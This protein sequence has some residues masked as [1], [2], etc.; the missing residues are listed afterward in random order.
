MSFAKFQ[1]R[2][3]KTTVESSDAPEAEIQ[4]T[5]APVVET[6]D[7]PEEEIQETQ[8][9]P[10]KEISKVDISAMSKEELD[11]YAMKEFD[12]KLDRRQSKS[13]ML[14]ELKTI[15]GDK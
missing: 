1:A 2:K 7:A 10:V 12:I 4:E 11:D 9:I 6:S 13:K 8:D 3:N 14:K 5:D 15:K